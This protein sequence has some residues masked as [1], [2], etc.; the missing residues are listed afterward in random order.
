MAESSFD[1]PLFGHIRFRTVSSEWK[2]GDKIKFIS[3]FDLNDVTTIFIPQ[4]ENVPGSNK[5]KLLFHKRGHDQLLSVFNEIEARGLLHYIKTCAGTLNP[6]LRKPTSGALSKL[7]SNHAFGIAIDLN[8]DD[9]GFGDS[10]TP[11]AP[12]FQ[13]F[14]F[15]WGKAFNDPMH[16]E[17]NKFL[18]TNEVAERTGTNYV[19][20][21]QHVF[22]RGVPPDDFLDQLVAWGKQAADDIFEKNSFSDI[23]SSVKNTLGPWRDLR[24]RRAAMLEVMRVLAGFESSWDWNE[25]RDITNPT[26]VTP[27]TIEAGAWQV[28]AD[29]MN[30]GQELKDLMLKAVGTID[31]NAFQ[32]SM[33][34]NHNLAME[35]VARLLRRTVKHHGPVLRH[36]IDPWLRRDAVDEFERLI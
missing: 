8:E 13:A 15:T 4:L 31:A 26:S 24:H 14:G 29:S 28:S 6:R 3:G 9:P 27:E 35:Y 30:F 16:F 33:K 12:V 34:E 22:N 7:P 1:H 25:G 21:K 10:V 23:Y 18:D 36:E 20:T 32:K 17:I 11:V 2:R 19:A 5:G